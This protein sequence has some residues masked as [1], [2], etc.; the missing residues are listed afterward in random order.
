[1]SV[2]S[3]KSSSDGRKMVSASVSSGIVSGSVSSM[4]TSPSGVMVR[5]TGKDWPAISSVDVAA[6][7][8]VIGPGG[9]PSARL[10]VEKSVGNTS[11]SAA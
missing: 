5:D 2:A 1:M 9:G 8:P 6:R 4:A 11:S 3:G 7:V 10:S